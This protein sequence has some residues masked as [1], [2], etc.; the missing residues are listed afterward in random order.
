MVDNLDIVMTPSGTTHFT[1]ALT[2]NLVRNNG[3]PVGPA[4][5]R[6]HSWHEEPAGIFNDQDFTDNTGSDGSFIFAYPS[7]NLIFPYD[8]WVNI[9]F[10][11]DRDVYLG[12]I[13]WDPWAQTW[14]KWFW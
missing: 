1:L 12:R 6:L 4:P 13:E 7:E 3:D 5:M 9:E 11:D 14:S 2:G 10:Y 8:T